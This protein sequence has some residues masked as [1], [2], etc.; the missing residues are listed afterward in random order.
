M[1]INV[2]VF[3]EF[4]NFTLA[5]SKIWTFFMKWKKTLRLILKTI[6]FIVL[7]VV[8][9]FGGIIIYGTFKDYQP[10]QKEKLEISG[11]GYFE[12]F[13]DS[14][15]TVI[16][17]NIGYCGLGKD[18]DFFYDGGSK[19]RPSK[20]DF[21]KYLNGTLN[22][23]SK[24]DTVDMFLLQEVD[25][26]ARRS[27]YTNESILINQFTPDYSYVFA[28]NY[29]VKF[30]PFPVYS[31]MGSVV[32]GMMTLSKIRPVEAY[33]FPYNAN[34]LWPKKIF[35][36]DRCMVYMKFK[37]PGGKYLVVLNTHNS[38]FDDA[39]ELRETEGYVLKAIMLDEYGRGNYVVAGGD[40]NRNPPGFDMK[41]PDNSD[42]KRAAE[43]AFEKDFLPGGWKWVFDP[44]QPTNRDINEAY[45]KGKTKTTIIDYFAVSP[46]LDVIENKTIPTNFEFSDHQPVF[47]RVKIRADTLPADSL[48]V[49]GKKNL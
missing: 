9:L 29:D 24:N 10:T 22:F 33:R 30:V 3:R 42:A 41:K 35:L 39:A 8:L 40:W 37:M 15:L 38:A 4:N 7:A 43:P 2:E 32:S 6:L 20:E 44:S 26:N 36:P 25:T 11:Q 47:L 31:P 14:I 16:S 18:M 23:L 12:A 19:V 21:R 17:W 48:A 49:K 27:Y 34:Y 46:N 45:T 1:F 5:F 28:K 13:N